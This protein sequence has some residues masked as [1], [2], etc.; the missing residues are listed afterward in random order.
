MRTPPEILTVDKENDC[1]AHNQLWAGPRER[2]T[3][4][5]AAARCKY[6]VKLLL[7]KKVGLDLGP[8]EPPVQTFILEAA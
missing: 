4:P 1:Y 7:L 5:R 8:H 3:R 6:R 2:A